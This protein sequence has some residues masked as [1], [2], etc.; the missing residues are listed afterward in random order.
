[1]RVGLPKKPEAACALLPDR[2]LI[3]TM[4]GLHPG[5]PALFKIQFPTYFFTP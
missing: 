2:A 5:M 3:Y 4:P 1:M